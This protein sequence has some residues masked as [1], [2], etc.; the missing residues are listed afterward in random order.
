MSRQP[1]EDYDVIVQYFTQRGT[2]SVGRDTWT[3]WRGTPRHGRPLNGHPYGLLA[4][5]Q[6]T[7]C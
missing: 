6:R 5:M 2:D 4:G 3:I 7:R 1:D